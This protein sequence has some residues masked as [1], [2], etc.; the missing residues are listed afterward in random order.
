M[1]EVI[2]QQN[3]RQS[4]P[5]LHYL[6][7]KATLRGLEHCIPANGKPEAQMITYCEQIISWPE[8]TLG[9]Y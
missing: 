2:G 3:A 5:T 8:S 9:Q 4:H 7:N 6:H 1:S